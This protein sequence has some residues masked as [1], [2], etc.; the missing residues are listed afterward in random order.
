MLSRWQK[1]RRLPWS[2]Q[3]LFLQ[4]LCLL[5]LIS[6][7]IRLFSFRRT[8]LALQRAL[9]VGK[10]RGQNSDARLVQQ[11]ARMVRAAADHGPFHGN[12]LRQSVVLW[13]LLRRQGIDSELRIGVRTA[14]AR[15][16]AHA[17]IEWCGRALNERA[18]VRLRF[19]AFEAPILRAQ[20]ELP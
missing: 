5:P 11:T 12:C 14:E 2:A 13:W 4:A 10:M 3:K 1:F 7:A 9:P 17:W 15:F 18:D 20:T 8:Q 16:E 19:A 6:L